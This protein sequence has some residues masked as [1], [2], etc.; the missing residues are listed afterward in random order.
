[1]RL[2][3]SP[4]VL[5]LVLASMA[6]ATPGVLV[7]APNDTVLKVK[8]TGGS[9]TSA[10]HPAVS[11]EGKVIG[12]KVKAV[13]TTGTRAVI[14][15][16]DGYSA[17]S[18]SQPVGV[19]GAGYYGVYG[20]GTVGMQGDG[21]TGVLGGGSTHGVKGVSSAGTGVLGQTL[22][23]IG[24]SGESI[25]EYPNEGIGVSGTTV[26]GIGVYGLANDGYSGYFDGGVVATGGFSTSSDARLKQNVRPLQK[27]LATVMSLEPKAYE[28]KNG[29]TPTKFGP[30]TK[31]GLIAQEVQVL[32]P[33]IVSDVK[34]PPNARGERLELKAIEYSAL[35]PVLIK[36]IQEQQALIEKLQ[37]EM[38]ASKRK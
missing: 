20:T 19:A 11:V 10:T 13:S 14:G 2:C 37:T 1:M 33:E 18:V 9:S 29:I 8:Y 30:G 27:G 34:G 15:L 7:E 25:G 36:A 5:L 12:I 31:F 22:D 35:I 6:S 32:L 23:G 16:V 21:V 3:H 26:N 17:T 24:V 4:L 38:A 28:M